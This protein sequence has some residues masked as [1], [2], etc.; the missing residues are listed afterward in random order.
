MIYLRLGPIIISA[1]PPYDGWAEYPARIAASGR[2]IV[3][4]EP[5]RVA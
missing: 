3:L 5:L 4:G 1:R 2:A